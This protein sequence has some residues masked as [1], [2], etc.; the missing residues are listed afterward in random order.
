VFVNAR[1]KGSCCCV[2]QEDGSLPR[3]LERRIVVYTIQGPD[4]LTILLEYHSPDR[5]GHCR[6]LVR[7]GDDDDDDDANDLSPFVRACGEGEMGAR[8]MPYEAVH[9]WSHDAA[10]DNEIQF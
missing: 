3:I 8:R 10:P 5:V 1:S 2:Q 7:E 6:T 4:N 9:C